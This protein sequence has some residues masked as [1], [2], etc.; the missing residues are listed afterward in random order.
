MKK[1]IKGLLFVLVISLALAGCSAPDAFEGVPDHI[2]AMD[3]VTIYSSSDLADADSLR[4]IP[5]QVFG[6]RMKIRLPLLDRWLLTI[7]AGC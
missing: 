7:L 6:T 2:S 1:E 5:E 4:L 3:D